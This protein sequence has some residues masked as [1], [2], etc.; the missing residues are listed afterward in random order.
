LVTESRRYIPDTS[1]IADVIDIVLADYLANPDANKWERTRDLVYERYQQN[2]TDFGFVY[3]G[4]RDCAVNFA[5][6]LIA[7]LYGEGDF[8]RTVQIGTLTGWD[9]DNGTA[10]VGG[11]LGLMLGYDELIA[12][13]PNVTLSDRFHIHQTRPLMPDY[14][15]DDPF[16]ENTFALMAEQM[17]PFVEMTILEA[18]GNAEGD[19]WTLPPA[20]SANPLTLN[21]LE[22][23]YRRSANNAV[24]LVGGTVEASVGDITGRRT[25][26]IADG[27]EH[28]FSGQEMAR[29][30]RSYRARAE[31]GVVTIAVTYDRTVEVETIRYIEGNSGGFSDMSAEVKIDGEWQLVPTG[32]RLSRE[33]NPEQ[34]LQLI[35]FILPEPIQAQGVRISGTVGGLFGEVIVLEL[36]ALAS[37]ASV[38]P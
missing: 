33:P 23:L 26:A 10:T 11:L 20:P 32:T 31:D 30:P 38:M 1:K 13:F 22:Q 9:S 37:G 19:T 35:D 14:L 16:A 34:T 25:A 27:A 29:P 24:R 12:Q 17:L 2:A 28:D 18:G 7:L 5:S 21:P 8:R 6:G 15:P 3:R 36:D 4:W